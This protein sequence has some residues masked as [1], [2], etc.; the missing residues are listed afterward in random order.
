MCGKAIKTGDKKIHL[1][2]FFMKIQ[3]VYLRKVLDCS[4]IAQI[5]QR[6][7]TNHIHDT[8]PV[9]TVSAL[10]LHRRRDE[11]F[12]SDDALRDEHDLL[13]SNINTTGFGGILLVV[14]D[15]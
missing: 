6:E 7:H 15:R 3:Q 13:S 5:C 4:T 2:I 11:P 1:P 8:A 12:L 14:Y 10:V 9:L